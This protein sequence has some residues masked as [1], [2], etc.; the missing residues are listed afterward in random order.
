MLNDESFVG[1][2][3]IQGLRPHY[4]TLMDSMVVKTKNNLITIVWGLLILISL[5]GCEAVKYYNQAISGQ[6]SILQNR[7]PIS[8]ITADPD[9]PEI[10]RQRL[11]YLMAV[12]AFAEKDLHLPVANNYLTYVELEGPYVAWNVVA[13]PEFSLVPRTWCYPLVGCT[14]YRGYFAE[15]DARQYAE[16]LQGQGYD[17]HVGGVT[18]YSTLGWFD[19]PVLSTFIRRSRAS[20]AAL[21]FHE[22]AHQVLYTPDDTTFNESF[23]T[24][25]EQEGLRRWQKASGIS[26]IYNEYLK[27]YRRE[28]QFI[29]LVFEHRQKLELLYQT[30][31][32]P[33]EKRVEKA[34]I[35]SDLRDGF[36]DLKSKHT[37]LE[38][39]DGWINRPLNNAK[40]SGVVAYHDFVPAFGKLLADNGGDLVKFYEACRRL[41]AENKDERHRNLEK[42]M[43]KKSKMAMTRF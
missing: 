5:A 16:L 30:D 8:K 17:V 42:V 21:L 24:F 12:R 19:D 18:A 20:A 38:A 25:V 22:L 39:Y 26:A 1:R 11:T 10:L 32:T 6:Q 35:F 29:E 27:N 33:A 34:S 40:I 41:A 13:T 28:Q 43:L 4:G 31:L 14:A 37:E 3:A 2:L 7:Q 15:A 9:S 23:A 36:H